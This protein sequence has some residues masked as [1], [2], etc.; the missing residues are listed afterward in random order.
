MFEKILA[1]SYSSIRQVLYHTCIDNLDC[2]EI[3]NFLEPEK[4]ITPNC[5]IYCLPIHTSASLLDTTGRRR[6]T[7]SSRSREAFVG[8]LADRSNLEKVLGV[9]LRSSNSREMRRKLSSWS[10]RPG[11]PGPSRGCPWWVCLWE[12]IHAQLLFI[13]VIIFVNFE[14]RKR[15]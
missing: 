9:S 14:K 10:A 12:S 2:V 1:P 5:C 13:I 15:Q 7:K 11:S 6:S 4:C 3:L 8:K